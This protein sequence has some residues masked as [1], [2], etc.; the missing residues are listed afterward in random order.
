MQ[1][2]VMQFYVHNIGWLEGALP[3]TFLSISTSLSI[4]VLCIHNNIEH[5]GDV[6]VN[7]AL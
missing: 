4:L 6:F 3:S 1:I 2:W 7:T 5:A